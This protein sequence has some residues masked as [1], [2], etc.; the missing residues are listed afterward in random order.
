MSLIDFGPFSF[1]AFSMHDFHIKNGICN[2]IQAH[3]KFYHF[4][5]FRWWCRLSI[6]LNLNWKQHNDIARAG[7][8]PCGHWERILSLS[9]A[10]VL[11]GAYLLGPMS[12]PSYNRNLSSTRSS[13][14]IPP[15]PSPLSLWY[16]LRRACCKTRPSWSVL[17]SIGANHKSTTMSNNCFNFT[18]ISFLCPARLLIAQKMSASPCAHQFLW[19]S[20]RSLYGT[21]CWTEDHLWQCCQLTIA[22][23]NSTL[24]TRLPAVCHY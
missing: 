10:I 21:Q 14:A 7:Y 3:Q 13:P 15:L 22:W 20:V 12:V 18:H 11:A 19:L 5:S 16:P 24:F 17:S 9:V 2:R 6:V 8:S 4:F 1:P 23:T